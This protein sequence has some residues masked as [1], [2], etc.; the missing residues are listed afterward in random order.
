MKRLFVAALV[1]GLVL[2]VAARAQRVGLAG[3]AG[4]FG[5]GG[6]AS[7]DFNRFIGLRGG[8]GAVPVEVTGDVDQV[9]YTIKPPST[10]NNIGVD[11]YPLGGH[12]RLSWGFLF[13]H[14]ISM[15]ASPTDSIEFNDHKYS[16]QQA[17]TV[18]GSIAWKSLSPYAT[19]GWSGR[20]KGFG[21]FFDFGA[22]FMGEPE[23]TLTSKGGTLS[24]DP[25]FRTNLL[26]AQDSAQ[27]SAGKYMKILPIIS[28]G[29]RIGI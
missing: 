20:G 16:P 1:A 7:V 10:M 25:T 27:R 4:M 23:I 26:A 13:K 8:I 18:S 11:L 14:D 15:D 6:E 28:L 21:M 3:R 5:L 22:S 2:P 12:W 29:I 9:S 19:M 24:S 17:G